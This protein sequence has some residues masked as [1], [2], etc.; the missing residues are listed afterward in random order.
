MRTTAVWT[1]IQRV[2]AL[3]TMMCLCF[4]WAGCASVRPKNSATPAP[5]AGVPSAEQ[6]TNA[7]TIAVQAST[8]AVRIR[9]IPS[10]H[11]P[12]PGYKMPPEIEVGFELCGLGAQTN[13]AVFS[14]RG[15]KPITLN[16]KG[17]EIPG[18]A[19]TV[20]LSLLES[21]YQLTGQR[22]LRVA[23]FRRVDENVMS[24]ERLSNWASMLVEVG[25]A[26]PTAAPARVH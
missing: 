4:C 17:G 25:P 19:W 13:T 21:A 8:N 3:A 10:I 2:F 14:G 5:A 22:K 9:D 24:S 15:M 1:H 23:L 11:Y 7:I 16:G 26:Q 18:S 12:P 6:E 20:S